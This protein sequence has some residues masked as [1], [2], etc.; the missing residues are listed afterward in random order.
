[1]HVQNGIV[2]HVFKNEGPVSAA[3]AL[4]EITL[5]GPADSVKGSMINTSTFSVTL[6]WKKSNFG[7]GKIKIQ[8]ILLKL[9]FDKK[10]YGKE[11]ALTGMEATKV[12]MDQKNIIDSKIKV[13]AC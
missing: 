10:S 6:D 12:V 7:T 4:A 9:T 1:M 5:D 3:E 8:S 13:C 2:I 11:Y